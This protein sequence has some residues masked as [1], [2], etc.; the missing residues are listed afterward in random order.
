[1]I[2]TAPDASSS[3]RFF[4]TVLHPRASQEEVAVKK[5]SSTNS[6]CL[7]FNITFARLVARGAEY[8]D[9]TDPNKMPLAKKLA[10]EY[11]AELKRPGGLPLW[12][13]N[14]SLRADAL[15]DIGAAL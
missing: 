3:Y 13:L 11:V 6:L 2:C 7:P 12:M 8:M 4:F 10:E 15:H 5:P 9:Q 1:M 14:P